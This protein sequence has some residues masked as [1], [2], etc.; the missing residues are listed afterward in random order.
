[1]HGMIN[2]DKMETVKNISQLL[3]LVACRIENEPETGEVFLTIVNRSN[4]P[5]LWIDNDMAGHHIVAETVEST[6]HRNNPL[7]EK[8]WEVRF[9]GNT[10]QD[11][12]DQYNLWYE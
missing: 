12:V 7:L 10:I 4:Y 9:V 6:L 11:C 5:R 3:S 8:D 2:N 1:M